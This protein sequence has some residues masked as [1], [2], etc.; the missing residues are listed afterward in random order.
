MLTSGECGTRRAFSLLE[1]V[2]VIVLMAVLT[3]LAIP[4][5]GRVLGR[6]EKE[7]AEASA[8]AVGRHAIAM[9]SFDGDPAG[10]A[11]GSALDQLSSSA[12]AANAVAL[13]LEPGSPAE[14]PRTVRVDDYDVLLEFSANVVTVVSSWPAGSTPGTGAT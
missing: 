1:L 13:P 11:D 3:S 5:F 6:A 9:A 14:S 4:T 8:L 10:G 12:L 7:T 2:V